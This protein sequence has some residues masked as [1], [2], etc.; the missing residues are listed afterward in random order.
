MSYFEVK[1]NNL[2]RLSEYRSTIIHNPPLRNLFLELTLR[3]NENCIHCGS[4][5]SEF[6]QSTELT[7]EQYKKILMM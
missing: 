1:R 5:C 2:K 3:C 4:K 7:F 6:S